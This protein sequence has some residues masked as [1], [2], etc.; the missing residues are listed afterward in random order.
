MT[1]NGLRGGRGRGGR[2][3][4]RD[5]MRRSG[6]GAQKVLGGGGG[7]EGS[8]GTASCLLQILAL[9]EQ[10][11]AQLPERPP[12]TRGCRRRRS[13]CSSFRPCQQRLR[14]CSCDTPPGPGVGL[15]ATRLYGAAARRLQ[16]LLLFDS[17]GQDPVGSG[18]N[19]HERVGHLGVGHGVDP[20]GNAA[21]S[22][23]VN[24]EE[25]AA[26]PCL[27]CHVSGHE[28]VM[29]EGGARVAL[30]CS[31]ILEG[32]R[33]VEALK[34]EDQ[35]VVGHRNQPCEEERVPRVR[36]LPVVTCREGEESQEDLAHDNHKRQ[37]APEPDL[38]HLCFDEPFLVNPGLV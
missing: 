7:G 12:E 22:Q 11:G 34:A 18:Q 20:P 6:E 24:H 4:G 9:R 14:V 26:V 13:L 38:V 17:E 16:G 10:Q 25:Q 1:G 2:G 21:R 37:A 3:S 8:R 28:A 30:F 35:E 36:I 27:C 19:G 15:S 32:V 31:C 33:G 29:E 23:K 5:G